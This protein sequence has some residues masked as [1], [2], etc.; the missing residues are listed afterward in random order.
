MEG[1]TMNDFLIV[2]EHFHNDITTTWFIITSLAT[3]KLVISSSY[4][5]SVVHRD[6][7]A[8][9]NQNVTYVLRESWILQILQ[10]S[11]QILQNK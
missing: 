7:A 10:E 8:T 5:I 6:G 9:P 4:Y 3:H 11:G 1:I 2:I